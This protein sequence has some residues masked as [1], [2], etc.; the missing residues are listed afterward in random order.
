MEFELSCDPNLF[1]P[2]NPSAYTGDERTVGGSQDRNILIWRW[3][4][5]NVNVIGDLWGN[6]PLSQTTK[7]FLCF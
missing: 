4:T 2:A 3:N 7:I 5:R 6:L 1:G